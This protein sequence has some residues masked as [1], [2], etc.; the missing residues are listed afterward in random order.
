MA[1]VEGSVVIDRPVEEVFDF[2]ADGRHEPQYH[3][4]M[5]RVDKLTEGPVRAGT[6]YRAEL[7]G[8]GRPVTMTTEFVGVERPKRI[9]E[10]SS[11]WHG[12][13]SSGHLSFEPVPDGT[14]LSWSWEVRPKGV[15]RMM[16]PLVASLGGRQERRIWTALKGLLEEHRECW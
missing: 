9:D 7:T 6:R 12:W 13:T 14:L 10:T 4:Q 3:P 1:L 11:W 16:G 5:R 2:V 8:R 15:M